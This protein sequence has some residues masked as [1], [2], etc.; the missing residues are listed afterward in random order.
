MA[1]GKYSDA[2]LALLERKDKQVEIREGGERKAIVCRR[3]HCEHCEHGTVCPE[4]LQEGNTAVHI[5]RMDNHTAV[6]F[7]FGNTVMS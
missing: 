2:C 3:E 5:C 1:S 4:W 6:S 7:C